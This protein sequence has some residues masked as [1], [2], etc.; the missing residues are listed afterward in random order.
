MK[1]HIAFLCLLFSFS[2]HAQTPE[3]LLDSAAQQMDIEN[4]GKAINYFNRAI[5]KDSNHSEAYHRR[6]FAYEKMKDYESAMLDYNKALIKDNRSCEAYLRRAD[7]LA[8]YEYYSY[9]LTDYNNS[10]RFAKNDTLKEII[11]INR[12]QTK[13]MLKDIPGA[14]QDYKDAIAIN[15]KCIAAMT[16]LGAVLPDIGESKQAIAYLEMAL[17]ID[18]TFDAVF[19]NLAFLYSELEQFEKALGYSN[20]LLKMHPNEPYA[21]NNRG[22]IRFKLKDIEGA[23]ED[24]NNSITQLPSNAYAYRNRGLIYLDQ[25]KNKEACIDFQKALKFGFT[26]YYGDEVQ[27][28]V[29]QHCKQKATDPSINSL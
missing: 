22:Y 11:Y 12:A 25:K 6:G 17:Q 23:L 16:N 28:L 5:L 24:I 10:F 27:K 19:G 7:L 14:V 13:R 20:R 1:L 9:A 3:L 18:S 15:P 2:L 26:E 21:L 29:D 8:R 4:Y